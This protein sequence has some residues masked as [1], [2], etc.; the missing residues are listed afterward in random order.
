MGACPAPPAHLQTLLGLAVFMPLLCALQRQMKYLQGDDIYF[1]DLATAIETLTSEL[2][3]L[4]VDP[5]T[6]FSGGAWTMLQRFLPPEVSLAGASSGAA[7]S[8]DASS[9]TPSADLILGGLSKPQQA[10]MLSQRCYMGFADDSTLR[11]YVRGCEEMGGY[12]LSYQPP[13][14]S[15]RARQPPV[16][17]VTLESLEQLLAAAQASG[18]T[19]AKAVSQECS[20]RF[21]A[22]PLLS[23]LAVVQPEF[24]LR[25]GAAEKFAEALPVLKEKYCVERSIMPEAAQQPAPAA[26]R[27]AAAAT[28]TAR[29]ASVASAQAAIAG[30]TR[31]LHEMQQ[32]H[33]ALASAHGDEAAAL[34]GRLQALNTEYHAVI[35]S[36]MQPS[37]PPAAAPPAAKAVTVA[38]LLDYSLLLLQSDAFKATMT[39]WAPKYADWKAQRA[40][41][42]DAGREV[43]R[44]AT[45]HMWSMMQSVQPV[46]DTLSE[47]G[48]L[49]EL[50]LVQ[51]TGSVANE[52]K[53]SDM[54]NIKT[55]ARNRLNT[56]HLNVCMRIFNSSFSHYDFPFEAA[57][58][59]FSTQ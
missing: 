18:C 10:G 24:W 9:G 21:P 20:E 32:L 13:R 16:A 11:L 39:A 7:S 45:E 49:A 28:E 14:P 2:Q 25:P 56:P 17:A 37:V 57:S 52:R 30:N 42:K 23:A 27:A 46:L 38:P 51:P 22:T 3:R 26:A 8:G 36:V 50:A 40:A 31:R 41:D 47:Y 6:A 29:Q 12:E 34:L 55:P 4:Y 19:A 5:G 43:R 59:R 44:C 35:A 54:N 1:G 53:F 58:D 15:A 48:K 33:T